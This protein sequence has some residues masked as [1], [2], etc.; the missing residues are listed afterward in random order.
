[1][2][3]TSD[4]WPLQKETSL[5][6]V[7]TSSDLPMPSRGLNGGVWVERSGPG[8]DWEALTCLHWELGR[9]WEMDLVVRPN[10]DSL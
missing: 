10:L 4:C 3:L 8:E 5:T 7:E 1:M 9:R 6:K 2:D